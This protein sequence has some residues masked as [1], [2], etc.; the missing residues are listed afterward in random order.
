MFLFVSRSDVHID[1]DFAPP[2]LRARS[3]AQVKLRA[4][5]I[6]RV[7]VNLPSP[8]YDQLFYLLLIQQQHMSLQM[9]LTMK[10]L[11]LK[12]CENIDEL[13]KHCRR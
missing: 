10:K 2:L 11:K 1:F 6:G 3:G 12:L 5:A 13:Y 8:V 9:T 7:E 4:G